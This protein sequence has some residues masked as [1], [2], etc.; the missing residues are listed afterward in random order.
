MAED[1]RSLRDIQHVMHRGLADMAQIHQ[2]TDAVHFMDHIFTKAGKSI[3]LWR[4]SC[5]VCPGCIERMGE[6]H[7]ARTKL[8]HLAQHRQARADGMATFHTDQ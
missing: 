2:H 6:R 7:I 3:V 1:D 4:I 5:A 8:I